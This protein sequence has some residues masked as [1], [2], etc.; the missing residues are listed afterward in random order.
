MSRHIN[1]LYLPKDL[2]L[3]SWN[4]LAIWVQFYDT[5][6]LLA[7]VARQDVPHALDMISFKY[8]PIGL[9]GLAFRLLRLHKGNNDLIQCQFL[10]QSSPYQNVQLYFIHRVAHPDPVI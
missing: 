10:S 5:N 4:I 6:L 2:K 8:K 3:V 9:E 1:E 7:E